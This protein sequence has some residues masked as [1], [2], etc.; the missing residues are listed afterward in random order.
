MSSFDPPLSRTTAA[1]L[2]LGAVLAVGFV[3]YAAHHAP[4]KNA[5]SAV[6]TVQP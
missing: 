6:G 1:V 5:V 3:L 4:A 2:A